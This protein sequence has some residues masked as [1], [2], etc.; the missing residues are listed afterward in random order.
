MKYEKEE[1]RWKRVREKANKGEN[2]KDNKITNLSSTHLLKAKKKIFSN[3]YL[4]L[5]DKLLF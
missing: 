5:L 4:N 3:I 1:T 2:T